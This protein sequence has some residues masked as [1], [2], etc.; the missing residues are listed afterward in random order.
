MSATLPL[1]PP[2]PLKI[3][4]G[5]EPGKFRGFGRGTPFWGCHEV[6]NEI[7]GCSLVD[8][9]HC[10]VVRPDQRRVDEQGGVQGSS[11]LK[12]WPGRFQDHYFGTT[13]IGSSP[14]QCVPVSYTHLRAH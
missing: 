9:S 13:A 5:T 14:Y 7:A 12:S 10:P 8:S 3:G 11:K 4:R 2:W 1:I 6:R